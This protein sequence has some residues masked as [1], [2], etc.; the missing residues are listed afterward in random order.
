MKKPSPE[1]LQSGSEYE[2]LKEVSHL[3]LREFV[4]ELVKEGKTIIRIYSIYQLIMMILFIYLLTKGIVLLVKG[5][6]TL[7]IQISLS[8]LFSVTVL[9]VI[10]ELLH[11]LA[12]LA[13]GARRI[14]FGLI[15]KKFVFYAMADRQVIA[16]GAFHLVA[17]TPFVVVKLVCL[18][19][20]VQFYNQPLM[21]FFLG[22]MCLHSL[23]CAGDIAMLAFYRLYPGKEIYNFDD[24][25]EGK[26]YFYARK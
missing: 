21:Y 5:D 25:S 11:A 2:L 10:H 20:L 3:H 18:A 1:D 4:M 15:L 23:F 6:Q 19:G 9:V 8:I 22:V 13:T 14:S 16:P 24:K 12:Y 7:L 26:T 17:L